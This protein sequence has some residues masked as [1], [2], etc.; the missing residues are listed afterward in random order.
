MGINY[1][2]AKKQNS[3]IW[4][5]IFWTAIYLSGL[6]E[7]MWWVFGGTRII[8]KSGFRSFWVTPTQ[9]RNLDGLL[10]VNWEN[11]LNSLRLSLIFYK[12]G[13]IT[14]L[15]LY[16]WKNVC[17]IFSSGLTGKFMR[18]SFKISQEERDLD[19]VL[20]KEKKKKRGHYMII[21]NLLV[22]LNNP[23][24]YFDLILFFISSIVS[25]WEEYP[26][27]YLLTCSLSLSLSLSLPLSLLTP[28]LTLISF[29]L[30]PP[31]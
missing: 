6:L 27:F 5:F 17:K 12:M 10:T 8:A 31:P 25:D 19:E 23:C 14:V 15:I 22:K 13:L 9:D 2:Q 29:G 11:F 18:P 24:S 30:P 16:W 20:Q 3:F 28:L 21:W 4:E 1:S 26:R 7:A